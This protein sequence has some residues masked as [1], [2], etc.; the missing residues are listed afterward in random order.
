MGAN[1][2]IDRYGGEANVRP[3]TVN[4]YLNIFNTPNVWIDKQRLN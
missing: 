4:L 2:P 3:A 1:L